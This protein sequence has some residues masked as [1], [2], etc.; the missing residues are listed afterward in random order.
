MMMATNIPDSSEDSDA[1]KPL[2]LDDGAGQG[3]EQ[4]Q[5]VSTNLHPT[6]DLLAVGDIAGNLTMY[7]LLEF[8]VL[9]TITY[10][11]LRYSYG[12]GEDCRKVSCVTPQAGH[13][14][15]VV[16]FSTTGKCQFIS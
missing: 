10:I 15:R 12:A 13:S 1:P 11:A 9:L 7:Y 2:L 16:R 4:Q 6:R 3:E 5:I 8:V 14:C